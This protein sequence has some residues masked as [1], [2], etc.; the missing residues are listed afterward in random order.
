VAREAL[1]R[2]LSIAGVRGLALVDLEANTCVAYVARGEWAGLI[3]RAALANVNV[4]RA[5]LQAMKLLRIKEGIEDIL[6]TLES[7]YHLI[8][9][10]PQRQELFLYAVLGRAETTLVMA[11]FHL[12]DLERSLKL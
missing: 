4:V 12:S 5:K 1:E 7:Q 3:E 2:G 6:I 9:L 11:R 8:R 10:L